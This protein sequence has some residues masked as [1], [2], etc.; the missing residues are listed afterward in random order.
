M[1]RDW[2][3]CKGCGEATYLRLERRGNEEEKGYACW[4]DN[5]HSLSFRTVSKED[6][7]SLDVPVGCVCYAE[8]CLREWNEKGKTEEE[9]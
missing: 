8:Y 6:W 9:P 5:I 3:I 4:K 2:G 1:K 7:S